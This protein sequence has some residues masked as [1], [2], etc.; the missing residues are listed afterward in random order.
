[1]FFY[2]PRGFFTSLEEISA[3]GNSLGNP[4]PK[5]KTLTT[6]SSDKDL[7]KCHGK[8][9]DPTKKVESKHKMAIL[10]TC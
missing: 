7:Q 6:N 9:L 1:M 8:G 10:P 5:L 3:T 4:D 2:D